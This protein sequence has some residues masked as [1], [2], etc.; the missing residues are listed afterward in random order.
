MDG[1]DNPDSEFR[2][3]YHRTLVRRVLFIAGCAVLCLIV[4]AYSIT[5]GTYPIT[6]SEVYEVI[7]NFIINMPNDVNDQWVVIDLRMPRILGAIVC[8]FA[9]AV[10]GT[11]MQSILKNPLA[12]PYTMGIS[13]GAGFGAA[14]ALILGV[15]LIAGGGVVVNAFVFAL[16]PMVVIL[17]MSRVRRATPTM[18]ILC[19]TSLMYMFNAL[20]QL[21]MIVADPDD[22]SNVYNW[23]VG[24]LED[25]TYEN[26]PLIIIVAAAGSIIVQL[27]ACRTPCGQD[28]RRVGQQVSDSGGGR[29]RRPPHAPGGHGVQ[30]AHGFRPARRCDHRMHRRSGVHPPDPPQQQGGLEM[31]ELVVSGLTFGYGSEP[32]LRDVSFTLDRPELVCVI[33]PNGV[34]KTTLVKCIN[35]L[36]RPDS[37][38]VTL[39]GEDVL[40]M[41]LM[42]LARKMAFVPNRMDS[43]FRV[44]VAEMVLMGRFPFAQWANSDRDLE[45]ADRAMAIL[46]LQS[47]SH[48]DVSEL[49][50]GQLQKVLIARG[51]AQEPRVL[52][53]DEPTSNLDVKHQMEVM[54][55][56]RRYAAENGII[57]LMVCHDLNLTAAYADRVI[58]VAEGGVFADG[59][60]WDVMT[61]SNIREVYGVD[62]KVI[63]VDG[64]PHIIL[65]TG[66]GT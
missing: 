28:H 22:L 33:G 20:T 37:G 16:I 5:L 44:S 53:L 15:E 43:V 27:M 4:L 25:I 8:G 36:L 48:R 47:L 34:G 46:N 13:S 24:T 65:L 55:F 61:E 29:L 41:R 42:D 9:L 32:L 56:L 21:F 30:D 39:D 58:M 1:A 64:R 3:S 2:R 45:V 57:V 7:W 17:L 19:G 18:M 31:T 63:E 26:L 59:A 12:D 51:L 40:E 62:S 66:D 11:A 6:M 14:I 49:S 60:A 23:M 35:K 54:G 52:I 38:S 10:C 50:S